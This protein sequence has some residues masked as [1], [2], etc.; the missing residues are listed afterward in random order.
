[1]T[2]GQQIHYITLAAAT[3]AAMALAG[4]AYAD[5]NYGPRKKG[6]QCWHRQVGDSLGYWSPCLSGEAEAVRE[7]LIAAGRTLEE[8]EREAARSEG[9]G[10]KATPTNASTRTNAPSNANNNTRNKP[11]AHPILDESG[12]LKGANR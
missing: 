9:R 10:A 8:A 4:A 7:R 6:D 12:K 1:M 11:A 5:Q 2:S 3:L